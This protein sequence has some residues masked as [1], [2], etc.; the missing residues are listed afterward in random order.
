MSTNHSQVLIIGGG[1]AGISAAIWCSDLGLDARLIESADDLGGQLH[2]IHNRITNYPGVIAENGIEMLSYIK[3]TANANA[4]FKVS[5]GSVMDLDVQSRSCIVADGTA[6]SADA[7]ILAT[8][9]RRRKLN[10]PGEES[11]AGRGI[12]G[13]GMRDRSNVA[14]KKVAVIG[15]GDAAA[16]NALILSEFAEIVFLIHRGAALSAREEFREAIDMNDR[17]EL[18][19]NTTTREFVGEDRLSWLEL[20]RSEQR[21]RLEID[22]AI[23]RIG[24]GPNSDIASHKL[25]LDK[26]GYILVDRE[27]A[28][29]KELI[30]AIGD[31]A[32]PI[33]PTIAS[34]VGMGATA[35]KSIAM[36]F[37]S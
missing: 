22:H 18:R 7:I 21:Q 14:G 32:N 4:H 19:L 6:Y 12:L 3:Q 9:V 37:R 16:E 20:D 11:F 33:A 15:G 30:Y 2:W 24:V 5:K 13:S 26:N 17:I 25:E 34:A 8:G 31:V 23:I 29:S 36:R 27:C 28:T 10:V 35:V 1:V